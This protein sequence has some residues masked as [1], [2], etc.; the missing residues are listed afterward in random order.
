MSGRDRTCIDTMC[1]LLVSW[2][3]ELNIGSVLHCKM[4]FKLVTLGSAYVKVS[5]RAGLSVF[6]S[7]IYFFI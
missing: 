7:K 3:N 6:H 1:C 5:K 2:F 4:N